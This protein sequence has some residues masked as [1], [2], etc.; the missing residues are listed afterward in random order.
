MWGGH[1]TL[2]TQNIKPQNKENIMQKISAMFIENKLCSLILD[3]GLGCEASKSHNW[4]SFFMWV[5]PIEDGQSSKPNTQNLSVWRDG[6]GSFSDMDIFISDSD[7]CFID[8]KGCKSQPKLNAKKVELWAGRADSKKSK[9]YSWEGFSDEEVTETIIKEYHE[10]KTGLQIHES[11]NDKSRPY[12]LAFTWPVIDANGVVTPMMQ[13]VNVTKLWASAPVSQ[14]A[15][16]RRYFVLR[17]KIVYNKVGETTVSKSYVCR[18]EVKFNKEG[19]FE[20]LSSI[21]ACTKP[22][23]WSAIRENIKTIL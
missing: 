15:I 20:Y 9:N 21:G 7:N 6:R 3:N 8:V 14:N 19:A 22:F 12:I 1:K 23:H 18:V 2:L 4:N 11:L 13:L 17:K 16:K 5:K 10:N